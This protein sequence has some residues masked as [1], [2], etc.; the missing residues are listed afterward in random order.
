MF[1]G[2]KSRVGKRLL[3]QILLVSSLITLV[4]TGS[5]LYWDYHVDRDLIDQ[6]L[7]QIEISNIPGIT[8]QL[9]TVN[10]AGLQVQLEGLAKHPDIRF[11]EVRDLNGQG[12]AAAGQVAKGATVDRQ[13]PLRYDFDGRDIPLGQLHVA[14]DL[15][16]VY[17]RLV[18]KALV[19]LASQGVKTFL[20][21]AFILFI[22]HRLLTR[23]LGDLAEYARAF[24]LPSSPSPPELSIAKKRDDELT[25]LLH[26]M[27]D[28]RSNLIGAYAELGQMEQKFRHIFEGSNDAIFVLDVEQGVILDCNQRAAQMLDYPLDCLRGM[29]MSE[30]HPDEMPEVHDFMQKVTTTG[31]GWTSALSCRRS[32]GVLIPAEIS[33]S[34]TSIDGHPRMLAMVRDHTERRR[35]EERIKH[36]AYHDS[37]TN[38]PNRTLFQDRLSQALARAQRFE[39]R[40]GVLFIDLDNFKTINDS[41]GHAAGDALLCKIAKRLSRRLRENDTFARLGGDEFVVVLETEGDETP[42]IKEAAAAL[43]EQVLKTIRRPYRIAEQDIHVSA[44]I[45]FAVYPDDA[46]TVDEL[47]RRADAAMY[48][49]KNEGRNQL[50]AYQSYMEEG[51]SR[52]LALQAALR[53]ALQ[54]NEYVLA[55]QPQVSLEDGREIGAE[56][57]LRWREPGKG[58]VP[59][60]EFI[61]F[62]ED[63]GLIVDVGQWILRTACGYW[64]QQLALGKVA[65]DSRIAINVSPLE[66]RA[67]DYCDRLAMVLEATGLPAKNLELELT[68]QV[69][70]QEFEDVQ[71]KL[72]ILREMGVSLAIDDFGT[73]YS[74]LSYLHRLPLDT[75]KIDL[76][77]VQR[78]TE[79]GSDASLVD[80]IIAM[81]HKLNLRVVAEGVETEEQKALLIAFGCDYAQGYLFGRPEIKVDASRVDDTDIQVAHDDPKPATVTH[82]GEITG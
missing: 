19:I 31:S 13:F 69:L 35:A 34:L 76:S 48:H 59:P 77:F 32:D 29:L 1:P 27:R 62:L 39:H 9:W 54:R 52:R 5:Q 43:A 26:A 66:L 64:K 23:H 79:G 10:S 68:E 28:M 21:S 57:L 24:S 74:S 3:A 65:A 80:N 25:D 18:D 17:D 30:I 47:L 63:S 67:A 15:Q 75:L 42:Q 14:A 4:L 36:M 50:A 70:I 51:A 82:I 61:P 2:L 55:V 22:V 38:L 6:R 8:E 58:I 60:N 12:V 56:A 73:G 78:L 33:A 46:T 49:A 16:A 45:G 20:V 71:R 40:V 44:S 81:A 41:L 7:K 11:L 53:K 37:L 72:Q